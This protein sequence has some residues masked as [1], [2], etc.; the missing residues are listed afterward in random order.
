MR[1]FQVACL[2]TQGAQDLDHSVRDPAAT[3]YRDARGLVDHQQIVVLVHDGL[4]DP[5]THTG[6]GPR[7][8][9]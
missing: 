5:P 3:M 2:W 1:Q 7:D 9:G 4:F 8:G 6:A